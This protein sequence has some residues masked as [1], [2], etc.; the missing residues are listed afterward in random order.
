MTSYALL[1]LLTFGDEL[2]GYELKQR[3][4][5]TMRFYWTSPA[6][7]QVYSELA[8]LTE[9]GL[10]RRSGEGRGTTY[11]VTDEGRRAMER[12]MQEAPVGMPVFKHPQALRLMIGHLTE[13]ETLVQMLEEYVGQVLAAHS[14]LAAV[15]RSLTGQD[16]VGQTFHNPSL[17]AE[18]GLAHFESE[19]AIARRTLARLRH[20]HGLGGAGGPDGSDGSDGEATPERADEPVR[21]A[22]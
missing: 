4:D 13:P 11:A 1:G 6:M 7:S 3:A 8:R 18:W 5:N 21:D 16:A 17:V 19:L 12:W 15:R 14:D 10:V 22:R 20:E 9:A 2:T